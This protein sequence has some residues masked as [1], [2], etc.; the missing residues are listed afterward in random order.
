[1]HI[2]LACENEGRLLILHTLN[3]TC[4]DAVF[5]E[6][7]GGLPQGSTLISAPISCSQSHV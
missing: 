6:G 5:M 7:T 2:I 1:M 4:E 3:L